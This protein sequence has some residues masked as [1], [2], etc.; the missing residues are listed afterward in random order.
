VSKIVDELY[1]MIENVLD[2]LDRWLSA[3]GPSAR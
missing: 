1:P 2:E 3:P